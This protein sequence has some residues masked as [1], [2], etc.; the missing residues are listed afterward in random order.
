M[1][2]GIDFDDFVAARQRG[3][4]KIAWLLTGDWQQA[5]DLLQTALAKCYLAWSRI[6]PGREEAY[7]RRTLVTTYAT[8]WRRAWRAERPSAELPEHPD[9]SPTDQVEL[10]RL[11]VGALAGLSRGQRAAVVLRHYCDLSEAEAAAALGCSIG[12]VKSQTAKGLAQL[13][14]SGLADALVEGSRP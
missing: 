12:T 13:R 7:V 2:Q 14:A 10:R 6:T 11:L 9:E 4:L 5:E 3:L 8:W 1:G